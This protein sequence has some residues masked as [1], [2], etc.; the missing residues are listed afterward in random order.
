[1]ASERGLGHNPAG[2]TLG[3]GLEVGSCEFFETVLKKRI[4]YEQPWL[5]ELVPFE[6]MGGK[7]VLEVGFGAG[8]DAY[9][10][11]RHG[12]VYSGIDITPE[13]ID[14]DLAPTG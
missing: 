6:I 1:M 12:A 13:N 5:F 8:Y 11:C 2:H 7:K 9:E 3:K 14:R 10:F 4:E